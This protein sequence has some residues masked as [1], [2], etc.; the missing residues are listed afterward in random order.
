[1]A[2]SIA[3]IE[4]NLA[5]YKAKVADREAKQAAHDQATTA[6]SEAVHNEGL[7]R[8]EWLAALEAEHASENVLEASIIEHEPPQVPSN[9]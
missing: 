1:M 7:T 5:D 2:A 9:T 6:L 8:G 3:D 4:A